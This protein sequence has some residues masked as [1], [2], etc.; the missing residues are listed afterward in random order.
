MKAYEQLRGA[1]GAR[2][3]F[4]PPRHA[5]QALFREAAPRIRIDGAPEL[6]RLQD[7]SISGMSMLAEY[8]REIDL[9]Q[10]DSAQLEL[11]QN[12]VA[13]FSGLG[14]VVRVDETAFG[15]RIA[16]GV[17][18]Q[19]IDIPGLVQQ[20]F[21]ALLTPFLNSVDSDSV[22]MVPA[23]YRRLCAD[24][25]NLLRGYKSVLVQGA[26]LASSSGDASEL[27]AL[28]DECE[29]RILPQWRAFCREGNALGGPLFA[30]KDAL[31]ATK[32]FTERV[33]MSEFMEGPIWRRSFE[34]PLGYP[35]DFQIMNYLYD[36]DWE[37]ETPYGK[38][39]HRLGLEAARCVCT[40]MEIVKD[41]IA[42]MALARRGQEE[43][44]VISL[45]CGSAREVQRYLEAPAEDGSKISFTLIDQEPKALEYAYN[46][47]HP[48]L[49]GDAAPASMQC[50][51]LSF[52]QIVRDRQALA[53]LP[54]QHFIYTVG[55]IDYLSPKLSSALIAKLY[56]K[57]EP[58]GLLVVGNM[59][60]SIS[61]CMWTTEFITDWRLIHRSEA[62]MRALA[63]DLPT[64]MVWTKTDS[65]GD[66]YLLFIAKP[67]EA[68]DA[69]MDEAQPAASIH[70]LS[71]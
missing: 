68:G 3:T 30:D 47:C 12:G 10:G 43:T 66:V 53:H 59:S 41:T 29:T 64:K 58:G 71:S 60:D 44:R 5:A 45:G 61:G 24:V 33:L 48:Y 51:N 11:V 52:M 54:K 70:M 69:S 35:G 8:A 31:A 2:I 56:E 32:R 13:I 4:R 15:T 38:L 25:L 6:F 49:I 19:H 67:K 14:R 65:T 9:S 37:G 17:D 46:A 26:E 62:E 16:F 55:L 21:R 27:P 20:N 22:R 18:S 42:E 23:E 7:V 40:R 34:K 28:L 1:S 50:L 39:L 63:D 57:L 36:W